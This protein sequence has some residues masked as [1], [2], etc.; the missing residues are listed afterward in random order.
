L[1]PQ[2]HA[3]LRKKSE[4]AEKAHDSLR[5]RQQKLEADD[6]MNR[7]AIASLTEVTTVVTVAVV[8]SHHTSH[9]LSECSHPDTSHV[10]LDK[11]VYLNTALTCLS[12]CCVLERV[13]LVDSGSRISPRSLARRPQSER[14]QPSEER[15][16]RFELW[17][18]P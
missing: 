2:E 7:D 13:V 5:T 8:G 16:F 15:S 3:A 9:V 1:V 18:P 6:K 12:V 14:N 17:L 10:S 11:C 4:D